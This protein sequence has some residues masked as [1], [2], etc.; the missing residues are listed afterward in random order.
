LR[1]RGNL[2]L[3]I[4]LAEEGSDD[5]FKEEK[6]CLVGRQVCDTTAHEF[7]ALLKRNDPVICSVQISGKGNTIGHEGS[8]ALAQVLA[9]HPTI[10]SVHF[11]SGCGFDKRGISTDVIAACLEKN[12]M[13]NSLRFVGNF[14]DW[15]GSKALASLLTWNVVLKR[16]DLVASI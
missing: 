7:S 12:E 16:L 5:G 11:Q 2:T 10:S 8:V 3:T 1:I 4:R 6:L 14:I 13:V 15:K 9:N